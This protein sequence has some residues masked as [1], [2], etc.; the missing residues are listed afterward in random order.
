MLDVAKVIRRSTNQEFDTV[1]FFDRGDLE[2]IETQKRIPG[3]HGY[4]GDFVKIVLLEDPEEQAAVNALEALNAPPDEPDKAETRA[5]QRNI[6]L[7][8]R[9]IQEFPFDVINLDLEGYFFTPGDPFPGRL[10]RALRKL[11]DWQKIPVNDGT[12]TGEHLDGFS[13]MF[14]TQI[15]PP[16]LTEEY[17]EML[18][19][20]IQ[21]NLDRAAELR[22]L[23]QQ[24]AGS[25]DPAQVQ[26]AN[27]AL[28]FRVALPKLILAMLLEADW[29]ADPQLGVKLYEIERPSKDGPYTMLHAVVDVKRQNPPST[30]RA[31][32]AGHA[33]EA[34]AAYQLTAREIFIRQE[35]S[36]TEAIIDEPVLQE[37]LDRIAARRRMYYPEVEENLG[38]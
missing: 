14:T 6:A 11:L 5:R 38:D 9:L 37:S 13:L 4:P 7:R 20:A 35:V 16:N 32:G 19:N 15:G 3:A 21:G 34:L 29:Y 2:V 31:P 36:V 26:A 25:A 18:R 28:F 12:P 17:L 24:R 8:Q 27:F 33:A 30:D 23:L 1:V 22:D 10:I